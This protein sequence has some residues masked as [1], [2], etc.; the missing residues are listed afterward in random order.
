MFSA[1]IIAPTTGSP[2]AELLIK[3]L[4]GGVTQA[5]QTQSITRQSI[6]WNRT[7]SVARPLVDTL[8]FGLFR[9]ELGSSITK[10]ENQHI[11]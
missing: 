7:N 10:T 8:F 3:A 2:R 4:D 11:P 6:H 1:F 5:L 9:H